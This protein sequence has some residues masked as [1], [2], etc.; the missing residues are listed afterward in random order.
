MKLSI[1]TINC[2]NREGLKKTAESVLAQSW[3]DFEWIIID[4]ASTDGSREY[5]ID[6]NE[7]LA[8]NGWNP[9]SYW[10]S[11]PDKGIFNAMNKGIDKAK[12]EYLN[13]MNSGDYFL[14]KD[15]LGKVA[16]LIAANNAD[17][18]YGD[19][20]LDY[21]ERKETRV[22]PSSLDIYELI[23]LPLCHQAM[24]FSR[25]VFKDEQYD[26]QYKI[27][28]DCVK[29]IK[30]MLDGYHFRKIDIV[31]CVFDKHG[32]STSSV[33]RNVEE[34]HQALEVIVP[35]HIMSLVSRIYVYD[36]GHTYKRV[37]KIES[38]G[39]LP[40]LLLRFILKIFG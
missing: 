11:E 12:G 39:G 13:F 38:K 24:F 21:G 16:G 26:E 14:D 32:I 1:I 40:A 19:C 17:V 27:S 34:F 37:R 33:N 9:I 31:V 2:N 28:C 22:H 35:K 25:S 8:Q 5:I 7:E 36:K 15:T 4:G 20:V 10:C 18:F 23:V 30:L 6:L 29:N 3:R